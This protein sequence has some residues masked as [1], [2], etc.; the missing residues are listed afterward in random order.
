MKGFPVRLAIDCGLLILLTSFAGCGNKQI[1]APVVLSAEQAYADALEALQS[2]DYA[3]ALDQFDAAIQ[4]GG[5]NP[6]LLGEA[7]LRTAECHV[8]LGNYEEA[9]AVLDSLE[10]RAPEMDPYHLVRCK[11]Y[12]KQGDSAKA[13][14]AFDAARAINPKI[15]PPVSFN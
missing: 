13:R 11:L 4:G 9:A 12:A 3:T 8:E 14:A 7:L 5:L 10:D 2:K 6:D 1:S 15:E